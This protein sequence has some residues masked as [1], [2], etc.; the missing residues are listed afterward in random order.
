MQGRLATYPT[1]LGTRSTK[2]SRP[3][4]AA[5]TG[6]SRR[7]FR[8]P[9]AGQSPSAKA[10]GTV[11]AD[12]RRRPTRTCLAR[13]ARR[14][15]LIVAGEPSRIDE[16]AAR[17]ESALAAAISACGLADRI[18]RPGAVGDVA[19]LLA[20]SDV[21]ISTSVYEGLSLAHLEALAAGLPVVATDVGGAAEVAR[22]NPAM[23]LLPA[24][25]VPGAIRRRLGRYHRTSARLW[26]CRRGNT[27]HPIS[28]GRRLSPALS[29]GDRGCRTNRTDVDDTLGWQLHCHPSPAIQGVTFNVTPTR[30]SG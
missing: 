3:G 16:S 13:K 27:L 18:H 10:I 23:F 17:C 6:H 8:A 29:A 19:S 25:A 5:A 28:H 15:H 30:A 22:Q 26:T 20:A 1:T 9:L 11:A 21:F 4:P 2:R 14:L 12:P 24:D 7:R